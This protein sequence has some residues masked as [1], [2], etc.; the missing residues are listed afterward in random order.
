[1]AEG[2]TKYW[3][4]SEV[5]DLPSKVLERFKK[6]YEELDK[7]A[8]TRKY[9]DACRLYFG[10]DAMGGFNTSHEV[11]FNG[12]QGEVTQTRSNHFRSLV[13]RLHTMI[14]EQRPEFEV[15]TVNDSGD[16]LAHQTLAK[17][18]LDYY[19]DEGN[20][21][22]AAR[23]ACER[24]LVVAEGYVHQ[25]WDTT[26][27]EVVMADP[28][29]GQAIKSGDIRTE[30]VSPWDVAFDADAA[31]G[32]EPQWYIVRR[33]FNRWDLMAQF[34]EAAEDLTSLKPVVASDRGIW[35]DDST[36][37]SGDSDWIPGF[38]LYHA[39]TPA[40]PEGKFALVA[41][42]WVLAE[43]PL[44]Y[45]TVPV[46]RIAP[47][48]EFDTN[49]GYS[50]AWDI[51]GL[52]AI[53]DAVIASMFTIQDTYGVPNIVVDK[54]A[55]L[56]VTLLSGGGRKVEYD[57]KGGQVNPPEPMKMPTI[58]ETAFRLRDV[59]RQDMELNIGVNAI[60]RGEASQGVESGS[61]AALIQS[62]AIQYASGLVYSYIRLLRM[63]AYGAV[64]LLQ[65]FATEKRS[66]AIAGPDAQPMYR[67]FSNKDLTQ[68]RQVRIELGSAQMRTMAQKEAV[69]DKL[70]DKFEGQITIEQYLAFLRTGRVEPLYKH[71]ASEVM[72]IRRENERLARAEPVKVL[73]LDHHMLHIREHACLLHNPDVRFNDQMAGPVMQHIQEHINQL[74][75]LQVLNPGL[76]IATGQFVPEVP[77]P[78]P[79]APPPSPVMGG[80][81]SGDG[82]AAP[83][84][85]PSDGGEEKPKGAPKAQVPGAPSDNLPRMPNNPAT[86][87]PVSPTGGEG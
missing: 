3:V 42:D 67:T 75:A 8:R 55:A 43:G 13:R 62:M 86:G 73:V 72:N 6:Y 45:E 40:V 1:V 54:A 38:F 20:M 11:T 79:G 53:Y 5:E 50:D 76:L 15:S 84:P 52:Q 23:A 28:A 34:P 17:M 74:T 32:S 66:V 9:L 57:S 31:P 37:R 24:A 58:P 33:Y 85:Q 78:P 18:L 80:G 87:K 10:K 61:H 16:A 82:G 29:S 22:R 68:V 65:T 7:T 71:Q 35:K 21:E 69:A 60:A 49:F 25:W 56:S 44:P 51:M 39:R 64:R 4:L 14:T 2:E 70:I 19:M 81:P 46:F 36:Q 30:A 27:G 77:L 26:M 83:A 41:G 63:L 48:E 12:E 59:A 47:S